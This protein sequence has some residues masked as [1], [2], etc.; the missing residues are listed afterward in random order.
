MT[1]GPKLLI[2]GAS[3]HALVLA[4]LLALNGGQVVLLVDTNPGV[5]SPHFTLHVNIYCGLAFC[6]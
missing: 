6:N 1:S 5:T 4:D 3:G 2:W